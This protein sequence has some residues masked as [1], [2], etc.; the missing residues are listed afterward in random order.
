MHRPSCLVLGDNLFYGQGFQALLKEATS[1]IIGATIFGYPVKD[2]ERY[3]VVT[4]DSRVYSKIR[5]ADGRPHLA[6]I[7]DRLMEL[8]GT[9]VAAKYKTIDLE[10]VQDGAGDDGGEGREAEQE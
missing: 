6:K 9:V 10:Q 2:P 5:P 8:L 3:G 7:I 4:F 1:R